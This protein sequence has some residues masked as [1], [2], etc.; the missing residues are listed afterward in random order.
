M[1]MYKPLTDNV[2][3]EG[4]NT[5]FTKSQSNNYFWTYVYSVIAIYGIRTKEIPQI[6]MEQSFNYPKYPA[7]IKDDTLELRHRRVLPFPAEWVKLFDLKTLKRSEEVKEFYNSGMTV[8][9]F[10]YEIKAKFERRLK[11]GPKDL[12]FNYFKRAKNIGIEDDE[13]REY[14]GINILAYQRYINNYNKCC[15]SNQT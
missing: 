14:L 8:E 4:R 9:Q 1:V 12:V 3:V 6:D 15:T 7:V 5:V 13:L 2:I 10:G 11:F